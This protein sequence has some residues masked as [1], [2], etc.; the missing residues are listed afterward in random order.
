[1]DNGKIQDLA[2]LESCSKLRALKLFECGTRTPGWPYDHAAIPGLQRLEALLRRCNQLERID[3]SHSAVPAAAMGMIAGCVALRVLI[4]DHTRVA[5]GTGYGRAM[6]DAELLPL[7]ACRSLR[8]LSA[9]LNSDRKGPS[10]EVRR[11][12]IAALSR[13]QI[14]PAPLRMSSDGRQQSARIP[15]YFEV[16][17]HQFW[18]SPYQRGLD[19]FTGLKVYKSS[20]GTRS[21][22]MSW[23]DFFLM[24]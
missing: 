2:P 19:I 23:E 16:G 5:D 3:F 15:V 10:E 22:V 8:F 13:L 7:A 12:L 9:D 6:Q 18:N 4:L 11:H 20:N 1:M 21:G 24:C 14:C 17:G